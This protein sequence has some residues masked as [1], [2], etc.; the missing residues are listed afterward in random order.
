MGH[1]SEGQ[2]ST[3]NCGG[4]SPQSRPPGSAFIQWIV[5]PWRM[6]KGLSKW[7]GDRRRVAG[8]S[9]EANDRP[10]LLLGTRDGSGW[11]DSLH[12][13]YL[14]DFAKAWSLRSSKDCHLHHAPDNP[15]SFNVSFHGGWWPT[16]RYQNR[17]IPGYLQRASPTLYFP[18]CLH[19]ISTLSPLTEP[20]WW[21][22]FYVAYC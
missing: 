4:R 15:D 5:K 7:T 20:D 13:I 11:R 9:K 17:G 18:L 14:N 3:G 2:A 6:V 12:S 19:S 22:S 8:W 10:H 21:F 16:E 1:G